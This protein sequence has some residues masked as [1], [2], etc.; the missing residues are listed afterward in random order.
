MVL[1][2][3]RTCV[4][5]C[6]G[7]ALLQICSSAYLLW[8]V[9]SVSAMMVVLSLLV[10][11][12]TC[13]RLMF[14]HGKARLNGNQLTTWNWVYSTKATTDYT[15]L[16]ALRSRLV[17]ERYVAS[18]K[19]QLDY[20]DS[21]GGVKIARQAQPE[22]IYF[23]GGVL[24]PWQ[25]HDVGAFRTLFSDVELMAWHDVS[26]EGLASARQRVLYSSS[27]DRLRSF[28]SYMLMDE[29]GEVCGHVEMR[30][31]GANG[32]IGEIS[33]GLSATFRGRGYMS[34]ALSALIEYWNT[35]HG[36]ERVVARTK[37]T[38]RSCRRL[39]ERLSFVSNDGR[40][41]EVMLGPCESSDLTLIWH[42][43]FSSLSV[44]D[45]VT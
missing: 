22:S 16:V 6:F 14:R 15:N 5:L 3:R 45:S 40:W 8:T 34:K 13:M 44:A 36:V 43:P 12:G 26:Q 31:V 10:L 18:F 4:V 11:T 27:C 7:F 30:L 32:Q 1:P 19:A 20:L 38:N 28:W 29:S 42:Q 25:G 33:F 9:H 21:I 24:A 2:W 39:L 17:D 41:C 35:Q 37:S 23:H